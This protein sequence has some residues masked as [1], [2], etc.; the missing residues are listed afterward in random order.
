MPTAPESERAKPLRADA[1]RNRDRI[2]AATRAA[3]AEEGLQIGVEAIARRAGVG[4][5]TL[6]RHFPT[7]D[8]LI[9]AVVDARFTELTAEA[10]EAL[11]AD[12][13]WDGLVTFL[14]HA[15]ALQAPDRGF[16]DALAAR[17]GDEPSLTPRRRRLRQ[18]VGALVERA[19]ASGQLRP[20]VTYED[21]MMLLWSTGHIVDRT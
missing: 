11:T 5:G 1:Q 16:K 8:A 20:D 10:D 18:A 17:R 12:D 14:E 21:M 4:M 13:A 9:A 19:Q 6:Y 3:F 15:L 2:V 7:K